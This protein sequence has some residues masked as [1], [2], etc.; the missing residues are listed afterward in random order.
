MRSTE[1]IRYWL[2]RLA[3]GGALTWLIGTWISGGYSQADLVSSI[4]C[5]VVLL[6]SIIAGRPTRD[7]PEPPL[8]EIAGELRLQIDRQ[9]S[10]EADRRRLTSQPFL[11]V[12]LTDAGKCDADGHR[13]RASGPATWSWNRYRKSIFRQVRPGVGAATLVY[14]EPG[15]GKSTVA[16]ALILTKLSKRDGTI[17]ILLSLAS[18]NAD[19]DEFRNWLDRQ[20]GIVYQ[21]YRQLG[22][23]P[24]R[25]LSKILDPRVLLVLDGLDEIRTDDRA[26][27]L[28]QILALCD[29]RCAVVV[30]SR[31][32]VPLGPTRGTCWIRRMAIGRPARQDAAAYLDNVHDRDAPPL[33]HSQPAH[34]LYTSLRDEL[35]DALDSVFYLDLL[36]S[37]L[38]VGAINLPRVRDSLDQGGSSGLRAY[39]LDA[40]V[41]HAL[42][43]MKGRHRRRG[44]RWL[45]FIASEMT[46]RK[47]VVLAWW[48]IHDALPAPVLPAA[49]ALAVA[50]AY[51]LALILP[52]GLTRG[53]AVGSVAGIGFGLTRNMR[54]RWRH[55]VPAALLAA[56]IVLAL[57]SLMVGLATATTDAVEITTP[58]ALA[59]RYKERLFS[60]GRTALGAVTIIGATTA[61][62]TCAVQTVLPAAPARPTVGVFLAITLGVGVAAMSARMLTDPVNAI[63]PSVLEIAVHGRA[64]PGQDL[65]LGILAGTA[66]GLAGGLVGGITQGVHH[67]LAVAFVFGLVVGLPV[68]AIGGLFK[69]LNRPGTEHTVSTP[70]STNLHDMLATLASITF[71]AAA[72]GAAISFLRGP[73]QYLTRGLHS[74]LLV[75]PDHGVL[76]GLT[77]GVIVACFNTA[78]PTYLVAHVWFAGQGK[79]PWRLIGY[80]DTLCASQ[81]MRQ[82]GATYQFRNSEIQSRL[83]AR[84]TMPTAYSRENRLPSR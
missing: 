2:A 75:R 27:A 77:I 18:W 8:D 38:E 63:R 36:R 26:G 21:P 28:A 33:G 6:I 58:F 74:A 37:L 31:E 40:H 7:L 83:A 78:W 17:P 73:L 61:I 52:A 16:L 70:R 35:V 45:E 43:Q 51:L 80:L 84:L 67:G 76:F 72:A 56:A 46:S 44:R 60:S 53:F 55:L 9:W 3:A 1:K 24:D 82:E 42:R 65:A 79:L 29:E 30:L 71:V 11:P 12:R 68:G 4:I 50:P 13:Y 81:I 34:Q 41:D 62:A 57:G 20:L 15:S 22:G 23:S 54:F 25:R 64:W 49:L 39:L 10:R 69:W 59:T 32:L 14:G 19:V 47:V 5:G 66:V 48:R